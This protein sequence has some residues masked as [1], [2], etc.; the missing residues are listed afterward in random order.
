MSCRCPRER[1]LNETHRK[2][3]Q[4]RLNRAKSVSFSHLTKHRLIKRLQ[5][6]LPET[7]LKPCPHYGALPPKISP[8][9]PLSEQDRDLLPFAFQGAFGCQDLL[10][11]IG[12]GVGEGGLARVRHGRR[13]GGGTGARVARPDEDLAPLIDRHALALDEFVLH[14][15]QGRLVE[16]ELSLEGAIG[17]ATSLAQEGDHLIQDGY[18]VHRGS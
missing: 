16:L 8:K 11:E 9:L 5:C 17:Q 7:Q 6:F 13:R 4:E 18:K 14:I 12:R 3:R 15:L 10:R 2:C 1:P